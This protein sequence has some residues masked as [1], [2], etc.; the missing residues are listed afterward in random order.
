VCTFTIEEDGG[1]V[2]GTV[3]ISFTPV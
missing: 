3:W 2:N 1:T